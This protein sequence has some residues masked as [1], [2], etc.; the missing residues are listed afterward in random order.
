[1]AAQPR[2]TLPLDQLSNNQLLLYIARQITQMRK[3][4][5]ELSGAVGDLQAAVDGVAQRL[6]PEIAALETALA[7]AQADDADAAAAAA[8]AAQAVANIRSEV[9]RL[10]ALGSDPETPV[11][12]DPADPIEPPEPV[13]P[14]DPDAPHPDQ[15]LPGDQPV[16]NPLG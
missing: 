3:D 13:V 7:A 6:L 15:S 2:V 12:V 4:M 9:D 16:V 11:D 14:A 5:T 1:M 10:N 8:D